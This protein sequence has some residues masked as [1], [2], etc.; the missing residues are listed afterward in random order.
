MASRLRRPFAS[1]SFGLSV[2][3]VFVLGLFGAAGV[4]GG[5]TEERLVNGDFEAGT[6]G[7]SGGVVS[8]NPDCPA[9]SG[10]GAGAIPGGSAA[11]QR[12]AVA[13]GNG[14]YTFSGYARLATGAGSA[15][16]SLRW[17]NA[18]GQ[19][20]MEHVT[21]LSLTTAYSPFSVGPVAA[22]PDQATTV[23]VRVA[24]SATTVC[25]DDLSLDGPPAPS[26]TSTPTM[27]PVPAASATAPGPSPFPSAAATGTAQTPAT[28]TPRPAT[29]TVGASGPAVTGDLVNGDFEEG[30]DGWWKF[31][32]ELLAVASPTH[33]GS[34]A[35]ALVSTTAA[36]KWAY[37]IVTIDPATTYEFAG[38][39]RPDGGVSE[40][41]LRI[42]WYEAADGSGSAITTTD[43]T[44][45]VPGGTSTY[46]Y[47][48]TGPVTPPPAARSARLRAMLVPAG[49]APAT[50]YM[51]DLSF[52]PASAPSPTAVPA[53][54]TAAATT[55]ATAATA[56]DEPRDEPTVGLPAGRSGPAPVA[57]KTPQSG[58]AV[59]TPAPESTAADTPAAE[60][61]GREPP[62]VLWAVAG[63]LLFGGAFGASFLYGRR[64]GRA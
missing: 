1:S 41:F 12:V 35:A 64:T 45:R 43:S 10:S 51:D 40:G 54:A 39:L 5:S 6:S 52:G 4:E 47:V 34:G 18:G 30:V 56:E 3:F 32:G 27:T 44:G 29:P 15:V 11:E 9:R 25:V 33:G 36:T 2:L 20:I 23:G 59:L 38:F 22:A 62:L 46:A 7:W 37:E 14:P 24:G 8:G 60:G 53:R 17:Y 63:V 16:V 48:S 58:T 61:Q 50:L 21:D 42:S 49:S 31:G 57:S 13:G 19:K 28:A 26:A 55:A